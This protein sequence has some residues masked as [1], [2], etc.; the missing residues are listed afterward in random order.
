MA[1]WIDCSASGKA[2]GRGVMFRS[3]WSPD[4]G[5][6]PHSPRVGLR[7]PADAPGWLLNR[8]SVKAFN[9]AYHRLQTGRR[10]GRVPYARVFHPLDGAG[11]WNRLYGRAGFFQHQSVT[12][13]G[14][15]RATLRELLEVVAASGEGSFLAVL[16]HMGDR[17]SGGL[18]SFPRPGA[19]R[20]TS[21]TGAGAHSACWSV[22]TAS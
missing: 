1:A 22:W 15:E 18:V 17:D 19:W 11:D 6:I 20:W 14:A 7:V 21:L 5:L 8:L 13:A 2:L 12:P 10:A 4:G 3:N 9:A 16:K